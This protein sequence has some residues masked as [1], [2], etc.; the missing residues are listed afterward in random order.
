MKS[1][2]TLAQASQKSTDVTPAQS[3]NLN[4]GIP[5]W[6]NAAVLGSLAWCSL[7]AVC[8]GNHDAISNGDK[9]GKMF[10]KCE[11]IFKTLHFLRLMKGPNKLEFFSYEI[12]FQGKGR[13]HNTLSY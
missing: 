1:F 4:E 7:K 3:R 8:V 5:V 13:S 2:I 9:I 11:V 6:E 12:S 10:M